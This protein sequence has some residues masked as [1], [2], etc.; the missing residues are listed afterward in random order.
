METDYPFAFL[1]FESKSFLS[2]VMEINKKNLKNLKQKTI[3]YN[4]KKIKI[5]SN[6]LQM[7]NKLQN[8]EDLNKISRIS[9]ISNLN[10]I[11]KFEDLTEI[12]KNVKNRGFEN[13]IQFSNFKNLSGVSK[14]QKFTNLRKFSE[15]DDLKKNEICRISEDKNIEEKYEIKSQI[16]KPLIDVNINMYF[17]DKKD[18]SKFFFENNLLKKKFLENEKIKEDINDDENTDLSRNS[19]NQN[20]GEKNYSKDNILE[21]HKRIKKQKYFLLKKR[22]FSIFKKQEVVDY[23][24]QKANRKKKIVKFQVNKLKLFWND[25]KKTYPY[26]FKKKIFSKSNSFYFETYDISNKFVQNEN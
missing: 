4:P 22:N 15:M 25:K 2:R 6:I 3:I 8:F 18:L 16:K 1:P 26:T 23:E 13:N 14:I 9:K 11:E 19:S 10:Q 24:K 21:S 5:H 20:S 7:D 12:S 17:I